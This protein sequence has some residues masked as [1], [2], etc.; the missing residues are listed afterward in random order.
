MIKYKFFGFSKIYYL[1]CSNKNI[2]LRIKINGFP[3]IY[4]LL[5]II[6]YYLLSI[7]IIYHYHLKIIDTN[8]KLL[9]KKH[10]ELE[11]IE[12]VLIPEAKYSRTAEIDDLLEKN[13]EY[14]QLL[15]QIENTEDPIVKNELTQ[16]IRNLISSVEE[17]ILAKDS[18]VYPT[19]LK[20]QNPFIYDFKGERNR[21]VTYAD[22]LKQAKQAGHD[23]AIFKNTFDGNPTDKPVDIGVIFKPN[24]IR[25]KFAEFDPSKASSSDLL[26]GLAAAGLSFQQ[27]KKLLNKK[28]TDKDEL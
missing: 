24:Q 8:N 16:K 11:N 5:F 20:M 2:M 10:K 26:A 12:E 7:I 9:K 19:H 23:S 13:P 14:N 21:P 15:N 27:I 25:G 22:L 18:T 4:Y 1:L 28:S 17:P 6:Y 3:K